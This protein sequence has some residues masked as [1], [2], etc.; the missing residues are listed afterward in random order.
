MASGGKELAIYHL[1]CGEFIVTDNACPH[2]SG[3]LS[4]GEVAGRSVTCP[5]HQWKFSL[6][7]G[8]CVGTNDVV[9]R[10]YACRVEGTILL[11]DVSTTLPVPPPPMFDF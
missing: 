10:R 8:Y 5:V 4:A 1:E 11:V 3:N 6:D 9:V 7:T 2:A